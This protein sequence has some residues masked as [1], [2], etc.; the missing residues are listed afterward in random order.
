VI[1]AALFRIKTLPVLKPPLRETSFLPV[2]K[3]HT[4][5]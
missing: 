5:C 3:E 1:N 4:Q 2:C